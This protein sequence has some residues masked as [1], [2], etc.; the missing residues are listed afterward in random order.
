MAG[1]RPST[2]TLAAAAAAAAAKQRTHSKYITRKERE[3][4]LL[5]SERVVSLSEENRDHQIVGCSRCRR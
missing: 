4:L 2:R 1:L 5:V 3:K